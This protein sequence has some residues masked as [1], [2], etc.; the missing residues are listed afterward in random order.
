MKPLIAACFAVAML[1][2]CEA[3]TPSGPVASDTRPLAEI[4]ATDGLAAA[5]AALA[6]REQSPETA[7]QLGGVRFLRAFEVMLQTRYASYEG[8]VSFLP[9][10]QVMLPP[11]P[12]AQFDPAFIETAF[13]GAL[14]HLAGA[15][16]ALAPAL[17]GD[18]STTLPLNAIW[19]DIDQDGQRAEWET[20]LTLLSGMGAVT[21]QEQFD[22]V[23]RFDAA[24]AEWLVAYVHMVS[25]MSELVLSLDPTPAIRTVY[26]GRTRLE[27][28]GAIDTSFFFTRDEID[29]LAAVLLNASRESRTLRA[30]AGRSITSRQ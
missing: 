25:G 26:E 6:S 22:G 5:D 11:N 8:N 19:M 12:K 7:F 4:L 13:N 2:A 18:F 14:T 21:T 15:E 10:M 16:A 23:V 1:A 30:R 27:R 20:L 28:A 17:S 3:R 9:G 29:Q 24:D